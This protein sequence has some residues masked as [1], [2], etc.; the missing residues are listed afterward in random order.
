[1]SDENKVTSFLET[2]DKIV[3]VLSQNV[4]D[5]PEELFGDIWDLADNWDVVRPLIET[6]ANKKFR[7]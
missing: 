6:A 1:M 4:V 5:D 7:S 2:M 3:E